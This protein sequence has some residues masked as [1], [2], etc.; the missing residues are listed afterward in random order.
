M[1]LRKH[2]ARANAQNLKIVNQK[3]IKRNNNSEFIQVLHN[4]KISTVTAQTV[5]ENTSLASNFLTDLDPNLTD[6]Y[7]RHH[8]MPANREFLDDDDGSDLSVS[9]QPESFDIKEEPNL[10]KFTQALQ[11]AQIA[12]SKTENKDKRGTYSKKSKKTLKHQEERHAKLKSQGF[13]PMG[14]YISLK[15]VPVKYNKLTLKLDKITL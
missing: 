10:K 6:F 11:M 8:I 1:L 15:G 14:D 4:Q 7:Y 3:R 2:A 5:S 12:A 9:N 13:F